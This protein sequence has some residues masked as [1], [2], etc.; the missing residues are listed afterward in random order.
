MAKIKKIFSREIIN[1]KAMPTVEATVVLEDGA[2][3]TGSS[4]TGTSVGKYEAQELRD[5]DPNRFLGFGV[6]TAVSNIQ[7]L[8]FPAL[9]G[10]DCTD[11]QT[12]DKTLIHLDGT[13]NKGRLGTNAILPVS[14]ACAK[15]QAKSVN[16]PLFSYLKRYVPRNFTFKIPN[17]CFNILNG[18]KHAGNNLDFQEFLIIPST[19]KTYEDSLMLAATVYQSLR[20]TL[21]A[22]NA[23]TLIGD[24]GGFGPTFPNNRVALDMLRE[25]VESSKFRLNYD[26][27]LGLDAAASN[28]FEGGKYTIKEHESSISPDSM[29]SY[30]DKLLEDYRLLFLEDPFSEDDWNSWS[31]TASFKTSASTIIVGDD[32]T[33]TNPLRLQMALDKKSITGIIIKPNQIG[34]IIEAIGVAEMAKEA[35]LKIIVSHRS[36]ET[37]D[38]FIADFS[39]AV[40]ADFVKFGAPARG[41]RVAKY[42]RLSL[43]NNTLRSLQAK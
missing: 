37:N 30:F 2:I 24:E 36:G 43:I 25:A 33:V 14:I 34:T 31:K 11:Q 7:K 35:G 41:E 40:G 4:P 3:G 32:L 9:E 21:E 13:P 23:S 27:F 28:L 1:S 22:K 29:F 18:G 26:V 42:N 5:N 19:N 20:K 17:P 6:L 12:I 15:A 38:D 16:E 10:M 39:V 8:I